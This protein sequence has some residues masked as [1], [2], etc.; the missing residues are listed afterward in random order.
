GSP[1]SSDGFY[2]VYDHVAA[3]VP[4]WSSSGG[5]DICSGFVGGSPM[6]AVRAGEISVRNLGAAVDAVDGELVVTKPMPSMPVRFWGDDDGSR[7]RAAYF[8]ERPGVWTHGDLL[9][10]TRSGGLIIGGHS[11]ATLNRGGVRIGTAEIYRAVERLPEVTDS[12]VVHREE[13]AR[14]IMCVTRAAS[15][16]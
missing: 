1:L 8:D 7:Y 3:D 6:V 2:W 16:A 9:E 10:I 5:T 4:V 12:R 13:R 14:V 11:D 15:T